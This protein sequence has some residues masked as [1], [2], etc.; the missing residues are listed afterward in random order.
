M[1]DHFFYVKF[2][3]SVPGS[4]GLPHLTYG[5][6]GAK[7]VPCRSGGGTPIS[8]L[9]LVANIGHQHNVQFSLFQRTAQHVAILRLAAGSS[10]FPASL[11]PP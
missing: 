7:S 4:H 6:S 10:A 5:M 3:G 2:N 1:F 8:Q 11:P 9:L